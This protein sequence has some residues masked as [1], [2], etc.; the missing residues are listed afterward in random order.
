[1]EKTSIR[2]ISYILIWSLCISLWNPIG[3]VVFAT[4]I[5][6]DS[7]TNLLDNTMDDND[8]E[9]DLD[10]LISEANVSYKLMFEEEIK[11]SE[12][13]ESTFQE[14]TSKQFSAQ[15]ASETSTT[16]FNLMDYIKVK[17]TEGEN[18]EEVTILE[19]ALKFSSSNTAVAAVS[20]NGEVKLK[21]GSVEQSAEITVT[22]IGEAASDANGDTSNTVPTATATFTIVVK[23]LEIT[24]IT[25]SRDSKTLIVGDKYDLSAITSIL[26]AEVTRDLVYT[27][28]DANIVTVDNGVLTAKSV[29]TT[30]V[31][32]SAKSNSN[33]GMDSK[34]ED[35]I[36]VTVIDIPVSIELNETA[37]SLKATDTFRLNANLIYASGKKEPVSS[38]LLKFTSRDTKIATVDKSG[39]VTGLVQAS[40]PATTYVDVSYE[41]SYVM[42]GENVVKIVNASCLITI[43]KVSVESVVIDNDIDN[44]TMKIND[45]Y[46]LTAHVTPANA[47]NQ[48]VSYKSSNTSV[49][50]V[51]SK[52]VITATGIGEATIT[53]YSKEN[54]SLK[55]QFKVKVYQTTFN[56]VE[57]GVNGTDKKND[58]TAI[59]KILKYATLIDE[60]ITVV[61]PDGTYYISSTLKIFSETNLVLSD[62]AVIRRM[63]SAGNKHMLVNRTD[64]KTA[65]YGQCHDIVITGGTWDGNATG[66][67]TTNGNIM[68]FGHA[69][70]ITISDTVIKNASGVH[71]IEF[72]GVK[73]ALVEKVELYG[74]KMCPVADATEADKEAIQLDYC[75]SVSAPAM[76]PW[77]GT[78]CDNITIRNCN[79]HDYMA[80]IGTHTEGS[81][82]STNICIE[83]NTFTNI[84]NA[85]VNLRKFKNVTIKNNRAKNCTTFVYASN[86]KGKIIGNKVTN[87]T[88]YK[89]KTNSGLRAKNGVTISNGSSFTIEKNTFEKAKSNGISIWNG[90]TAVIKNN[91]IKGNK[92]YGIRTQG[93]TVTLKKNSFSKNKKGLYDTYKDAKIKSSDDI[94]AYYIDIKKSYSYNGKP[95]KPKISIK[96]LSKKY[97]KVSYKNYKKTGTA[98]VIIK[99]KGKVKKTLQIKYVIK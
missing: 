26:P 65:G 48:T 98:T 37:Y 68:Y 5:S 54:S 85:C 36:I 17:K 81:K 9:N 23:A 73:K 71:L 49:A 64:G 89:A 29:G 77:D 3:A 39:L 52:G 34:I 40:Y 55:D 91:K 51:S 94:R 93:S 45:K 28:D 67:E 16:P 47:S 4:S 33:T 61:V 44:I 8:L 78:P 70:N 41:K 79:I 86:S 99:G 87:G 27:V 19:N 2:I 14:I 6:S 15:E 13:M 31:T 32:V 74:Y 63:Q 83:N 59:N 11:D 1:M 21:A 25:I 84:T 75:S 24:D 20:D 90:S 56:I 18:T 95:I 76:K 58:A 60:P 72:A 53:V 46:T 42:D 57:L 12:S 10:A 62:N 82:A 92:L 35:S 22:W 97:Y 30:K 69:K 88:S 66:K 80:G 50:K 7:N 96:G 38:N 43:P